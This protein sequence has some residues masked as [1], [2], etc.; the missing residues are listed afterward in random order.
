MFGEDQLYDEFG[1]FLGEFSEDESG[2]E[3]EEEKEERQHFDDPQDEINHDL[4]QYEGGVMNEEDQPSL[5]SQIVLHEDKEYYPDAE[6]VFP[7]VK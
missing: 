5:S 1:N 7:G 6:E 3:Y 2:S 4:V